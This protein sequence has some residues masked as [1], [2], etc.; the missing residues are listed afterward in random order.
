MASYPPTPLDTP[1]LMSPVDPNDFIT[2]IAAQERR[3]LELREE[4]SRA[5]S[6][7]NKLKKQWTHS[8]A[9]KKHAQIRNVEPL[10]PLVP[11]IDTP[12]DPAKAELDRR[13]QLLLG[14]QSKEGTPT[15][16]Y[17]RRVFRGGHT[18]TLSLLS[19]TKPTGGGF[20]VH[21]DTARAPEAWKPARRETDS[22]SGTGYTTIYPTPSKRASWAPRSVHQQTSGVKQI[23][24]DLKSG[25]WTFMEDLRQ[26]TVG[27][28]PITGQ[29]TYLRGIDGNMRST[30]SSSSQNR[31]E[32]QETI[33]ASAS[34]AARPHASSVF[35]YADETPTPASRF[36]DRNDDD[37]EKENNERPPGMPRQ[38]SSSSSSSAS[39]K[40][41]ALT[42]N[43]KRFSWT[44]LTIDSYD[45]SDW[46]N[47]ESPSVK[48]PR[49]SGS[50]M[51]GDIITEGA[52]DDH[53]ITPITTTNG[54]RTP[55]PKKK[56]S[57]SRLGL[58]P[59]TPSTPSASS[60]LSNN[61]KLEELLPPVLNRLTPSNLKKTA[62]DFMKEWEKSLSPPP[63]SRDAAAGGGGETA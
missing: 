4:L 7:L 60:T 3:V 38:N 6:Q 9:H 53:T 34:S 48:S 27:D 2:A 56:P 42:K 37:K 17:R 47:W 36:V 8:E 19:P 39:Q 12:D 32:N 26:A 61:T 28:E 51:N 35:D 20:D 63:Q 52:G 15:H 25:L 54:K 13:K 23:A 59:N 14:Q 57:A 46:S 33:R 24:E 50:T 30:S 55:S 31:D 10:R 18:R 21:E 11:H 43:Q 62:S 16:Q 29:G 58:G 44:P 5:E 22:P 49:W 1:S 41:A 45:D 40:M